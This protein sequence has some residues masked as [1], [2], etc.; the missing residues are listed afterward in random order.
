MLKTLNDGL[1]RLF[2]WAAGL[3]MA[4]VF[5]IIFLNSS[6]RYGL[7]RSW[8]WGEELP[9]YLAI[10]GVMF[11]VA[12]AYLQD[13]H[14][15][16]TILTDNLPARLR[17]WL[18]AAVDL[19]M[20]VIGVMLARS[21]LLFIDSRG[22]REASGIVTAARRLARDTGIE[23][24]EIF[25]RMAPWQFSFVLGGGILSL[26]AAVRLARR[27]SDLRTSRG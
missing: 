6:R 14:I 8:A 12:M 3:C 26:A 16:F 4:G 24:I 27:I 15:R 2:A 23:W 22:A 5:L 17:E 1:C 19:A 21:A 18:F 11:G 9:I 13:R 25:G 20:V 7:G 10:Y